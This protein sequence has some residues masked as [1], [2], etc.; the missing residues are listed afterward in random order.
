MKKKFTLFF[1]FIMSVNVLIAQEQ[2]KLNYTLVKKILESRDPN[3]PAALFVQGD[4]NFIKSKTA[5]LG[6]HFKYSSG[7]VAAIVLPISKVNTLAA[8]P[9]VIRM[10][11]NYMKL[12]PMNDSMVVKNRIVAAYN[13]DA[14]LP[15]GYDGAG[16]VMGIIDS[17]IDFTHPDFQDSTGATR[18]KFL[19]NQAIDGTLPQ[20]YGYGWEFNSQNIN[21]GQADTSVDNSN[22]HGTH[23]TGIAAGNGRALNHFA[24][25]APK[26]DII[27]VE[28]DWS[29]PDDNWLNSV[30]DAV[31]YIYTKAD[32]MGEPCVINISAG[33]IFGSHDAK[34]LQAVIISNLIS[35][36]N[37]RSLVC[38]AG[39]FG[40]SPLHLHHDIS[41][42]DTAFTWFAYNPN[43]GTSIYIEMWANQANFTAMKFTIGIDKVSPY[44]EFRGMMPY[45]MISQ[46]VGIFK[47]D[48]LKN[49]N[50]QRVALVQSFGSL[51]AGRYSMIFNILP[52]STAGYNYRL[53]TTGTGIF[54]LWNYY[55]PYNNIVSTGLPTAAIFPDISKYILPDYT[56]NIVSSFTCS[57]KVIAVGNYINKSEYEACDSS[58]TITGGIPGEL[59]FNSSFG[60]TR[61]GRIKPDVTASGTVTIAPIVL[62]SLPVTPPSVIASGCMH[63][64]DGGTSS[65][66]P[67]VAGVA[68]LYLQRFPNATWHDVKQAI[69]LCAYTDGFVTGSIPNNTW[70]YGKVDGFQTI[71][72]C[73]LVGIK[74][75]ETLHNS[76]FYFSPNPFSEQ[77]T[78]YYDLSN[79][80]TK[81]GEIKIFD[82]I[83]N[84]AKKIS[85][86]KTT[87]E[88][89]LKK[90]DLNSGVY[91]ISLVANKQTL[92]TKKL[93][94]L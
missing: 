10:E 83:G 35:Q 50:G 91:F 58:T 33:V 28:V 34:D 38:A 22:G 52:D 8:D 11:D 94:I 62:A 53:M 15:Q 54:D 48:T 24:G 13:G 23:V 57:D 44:Y 77:T 92:V 88:I 90:Q 12:Q 59:A 66:S 79:L 47:T 19:W 20:P 64:R 84:L 85:V 87:G 49:V 70:G 21:N 17:G 39:N 89:T 36:Q 18:V 68:A 67:V 43:I 74:E 76:N 1:L 27:S 69:T 51:A 14:P 5:E 78:I 46:H 6:G 40:N 55:A 71:I 26:A 4:I 9:K 25:V 72:P 65:S 61:D 56:Q 29:L 82:A 42:P 7:D 93:V 81:T 32:S 45:S 63:K 80:N 2:A 41:P 60:P 31:E 16:V 73:A 75:N 37:G 3:R 30:A 86:T